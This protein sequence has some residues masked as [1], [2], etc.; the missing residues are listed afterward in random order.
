M[1]HSS[2]L[3]PALYV[4]LCAVRLRVICVWSGG[5]LRMER[6]H[7]GSGVGDVKGSARPGTRRTRA[8]K[9]V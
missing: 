6:W 8:C 3:E 2:R 9:F 7:G 4:E 5:A 1:S